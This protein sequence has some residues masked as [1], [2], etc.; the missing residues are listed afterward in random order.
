M[1]CTFI[2]N[3]TVVCN[4]VHSLQTSQWS[5]IMYICIIPHESTNYGIYGYT[6]LYTLV[7]S[8]C[9]HILSYTVYGKTFEVREEI[10]YSQ[11]DFCKSTLVETYITD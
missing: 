1:Q 9:S 2:T 8:A 10:G 7:S 4:N 11:E 3:L 6:R 5:V